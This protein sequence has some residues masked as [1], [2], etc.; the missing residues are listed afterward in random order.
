MHLSGKPV[1]CPALKEFIIPRK[2]N[3]PKMSR[4]LKA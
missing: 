1:L 4:Q 3:W 2:Y